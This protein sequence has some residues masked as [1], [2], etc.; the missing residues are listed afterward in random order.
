MIIG[1][2]GRVGVGKS[3]LVNSLY[4][5]EVVCQIIDLHVIGHELLKDP[6]IKDALVT[7]FGH[8]ILDKNDMISR[9]SLSR[10]VFEN[11]E[12]L[13]V[14]NS[15]MHPK[16]KEEVLSIIKRIKR[17]TIIVVGALIKEIKLVSVCD[18]IVCVQADREKREQLLT[19]KR[20]IQRFQLSDA[21]YNAF[22]DTV[23]LNSYSEESVDK[24][25]E[26]IQTLICFS[27]K[28]KE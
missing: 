25:I 14:L 11:H 2:T 12:Q 24:F 6:G 7:E 27:S 20:H 4:V 16:I 18:Y 28:E 15:I 19:K 13:S 5:K 21:E 1:V 3:Y 23:F 22:S 8:K 10:I 17:K 26:L 9:P